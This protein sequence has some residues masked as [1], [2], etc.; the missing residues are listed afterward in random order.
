MAETINKSLMSPVN[1]VKMCSAVGTDGSGV[2]TFDWFTI[3]NNL[4]ATFQ[5]LLRGTLVTHI[6]LKVQA[7]NVGGESSPEDLVTVDASGA[8]VSHTNT[9]GFD[10]FRIVVLQQDGNGI[11]SQVRMSSRP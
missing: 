10:K 7:C 9:E 6:Q 1:G 3:P 5:F 4:V 11:R 2:Q 8:V